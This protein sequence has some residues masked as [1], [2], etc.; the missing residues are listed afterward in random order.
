[1]TIVTAVGLGNV[2]HAADSNTRQT[3]GDRLEVPAQPVPL[4]KKLPSRGMS[5]SQVER[6]W[7]SPS[8]RAGPV[9]R[10]PISRWVYDEFTVY[11]EHQ[12]VIHSVQHHRNSKAT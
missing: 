3:L 6:G 5:M 10:P 8:R 7:G 2:A 1:M 9:G 4:Q 12:H 11:F